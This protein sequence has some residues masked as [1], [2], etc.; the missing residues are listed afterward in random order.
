MEERGKNSWRILKLPMIG[1][2][3]SVLLFAIVIA[4]TLLTLTPV[5]AQEAEVTVNAPEYVKE[6][7]TFDVTIDVDSV[8][9]FNF[10]MFDLSFDHHVM[11]VTDV[12]D[13]RIDDTKIPIPKRS[14]VFMDSDTIKVMPELSGYATVSGSGYLAKITFKVKGKEGDESVLDISNGELTK[15]VKGK[16]E[17]KIAE[18]I[19]A[20]W[21]DAE[22]RVDVEEEDEEEE[23]EGVG[24]E[25]IQGSPNIADWKPAEAVIS[26]TVGEP[27]TFNIYVNQIADIRWQINGTRVQTN[28]SIIEATY[29]NTSAVIGTWNISVIAT[30]TTTGL[31]DMHT[32]IWSVIPTA[33][34]TPTPTLTPEV[35]PT[36]EA[37][38]T[39]TLKPTPTPT[40]EGK[41]TPTPTPKPA[42]PGFE[43]IFA[44]A[45]MSAIAYNLLR[46]RE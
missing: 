1:T 3:M 5:M 45:V 10:G 29:T 7:A 36:P 30:N 4:V 17:K 20:N 33:T 41:P 21:T 15:L 44:I 8:T 35:T 39:P 23:E 38:G 34:V 12:T 19:L 37:E 2:G 11:E 9:D 13:G 28:E 31:L 22:V 32:W 25:L 14:Y 6:G 26:N 16:E 40:T 27:R 42:V 24:E 18:E 43:A 46:G